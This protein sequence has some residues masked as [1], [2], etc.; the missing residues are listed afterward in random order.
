MESANF[1]PPIVIDVLSHPGLSVRQLRVKICGKVIGKGMYRTVYELKRDP[2]Y[3]VK[4]E[5]DPSRGTFA[6][7]TEWRNYINNKDWNYLKDWLAPCIGINETGQVLIQQRIRHG[8][9]KDYPKY[10]PAI[11]TDL[12]LS[13]FGWIGDKFVCCDYSY[14]TPYI[15][16]AGKSK[17]KYA[18]WWGTLKHLKNNKE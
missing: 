3:V 8:R 17:M 16:T 1:K 2:D 9:R 4:I 18:K 5:R 7:V 13:N 14:F 6:N 10:V 12:K 11:F 15:I